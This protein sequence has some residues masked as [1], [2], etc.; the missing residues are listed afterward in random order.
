M[1]DY[2]CC[3]TS[4]WVLGCWCCLFRFGSVLGFVCLVWFGVVVLVCCLL[5][6]IGLFRLFVNS[7]VVVL[8]W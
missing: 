8:S 4:V 3:F 5:L 1:F 6:L 7:V 2:C